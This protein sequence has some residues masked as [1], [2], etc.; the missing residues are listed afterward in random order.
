MHFSHCSRWPVMVKQRSLRS[1]LE[2]IEAGS[3]AGRLRALMP[4]IEHR[5]AAGVRIADIV[6]ALNVNGLPITAATLKSY[7]YRFRK[8]ARQ[9]GD[10][11]P[12]GLTAVPVPADRRIS[13]DKTVPGISAPDSTVTS[14][15]LMRHIN[16]ARCLRMLKRGAAYSRAE[17]ARELDLTRATIGRAIRDLIDAGLI[18]EIPD[19]PDGGRLGRPGSGIRLNPR[20]AYSIGVDVSSIS[21]TGVLVDL[22]MR[23]VGRIRVP[24]GPD[25]E[26]VAGVVERIAQFPARLLAASDVDPKLVQGVCV[27]APGLVDQ[28][29]TVVVA[30]FL[31]WHDVPLRQL[32]ASRKDLPWPVTVCNDAVAFATAEQAVVND[33]EAQNMLLLL[34][35]EGLGGAIVQ[36]GQIFGG[37]HGYAGELGHMVMAASPGAIP[38]QTF[39]LLA[40]YERF[41]PFLPDDR[42]LEDG[43]MLL[44]AAGNDPRVPALDI[45]FDT[46][47]EVLAAG[48]L[49]L[50]YL[51]D[52]EK[53]V[54]GG[55]LSLLFPRV[56]S[57][58]TA[59]V[60]KNL[61]HG[62]PRP[63]IHITR[64]GA[65]GAAVG[66]ASVVRDSI[67]SLPRLE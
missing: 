34:L 21:L 28:N 43:L 12:T 58:V 63:P 20:G 66:A 41:R 7:L 31:H 18:V 33:K 62:F 22:D 3:K 50:I 35:T 27:S 30:P 38:T 61:L 49:N 8:A 2:K 37:A 1:A 26:D 36:R 4:D 16:T 45:V 11:D 10:D 32:L 13:G 15:G 23:V 65:D 46:W 25:V 53:V 19:R 5:I 40:G 17:L 24:I 52:P 48:L 55:P 47:A 39:E 42:S 51:F 67:F 60:A 64:F 6:H 9:N 14:P 54:L 57:R 44:A 56:R 59:L 29:G